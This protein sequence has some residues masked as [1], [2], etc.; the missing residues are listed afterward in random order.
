[1][2]SAFDYFICLLKYR[3]VLY[4]IYYYC[5]WPD[6]ARTYLREKHSRL[7]KAERALI[8]DELQTW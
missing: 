5:V 7:L 4:K 3:I 8:Y 1:M 2:T 6:N